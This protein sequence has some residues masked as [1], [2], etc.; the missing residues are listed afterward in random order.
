MDKL[1]GSDWQAVCP[2]QLT[3]EE[4][5]AIKTALLHSLAIGKISLR[6]YLINFKT[7]SDYPELQ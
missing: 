7:V 6:N 1:L 4:K 5:A 2:K 3:F